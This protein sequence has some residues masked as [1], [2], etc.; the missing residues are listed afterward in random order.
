MVKCGYSPPKW[1]VYHKTNIYCVELEL[2][3]KIRQINEP[4]CIGEGTYRPPPQKGL[5][6]NHPI[7]ELI[8]AMSENSNVD[9]ATEFIENDSHRIVGDNSDLLYLME[10][11][12]I[13]FDLV[14]N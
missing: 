3:K 1:I 2:K 10:Q 14:N 8:W 13:T 11:L 7:K 6:F 12:G 4:C 5:N 9:N